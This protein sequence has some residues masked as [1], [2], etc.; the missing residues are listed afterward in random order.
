MKDLKIKK[1]S[2]I[3]PLPSL[4]LPRILMR[5]P[6]QQKEGQSQNPQLQTP[7]LSSNPRPSFSFKREDETPK[8][9]LPCPPS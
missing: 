4:L 5:F 9:I 6:Y 7:F 3:K 2:I 1:I 8:L